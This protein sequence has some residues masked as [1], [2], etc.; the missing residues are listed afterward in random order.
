MTVL[1]LDIALERAGFRLAVRHELA[2]SGITALFGPSG[3]GKTTLLRVIAGLEERARGTVTFDGEPWQR[4]GAL[5]PA[6]RRGIGYVF[7]D[8]RLFSHLT[9]EGN[10]RFAL[11]RGTNRP[12]AARRID[13][14]AAVDALGLAPL[15]ARRPSTLSGGEQQRVAIARALLT[16]PRLLLMDE[17]LSSLDLERKREIVPHIEALPSTFGVPVIYV[18]HSIDEVTRLATDAVLLGAGTIV[19]AGPVA[20]VLGRLDVAGLMGDRDTGAVLTVR[21]DGRE[22]GV[23]TLRLDRQTL[24]VPL[25]DSPVGTQLRIRIHARD[26][27]LA[28]GRPTG[29]SIRNIL[30][31]RIVQIDASDP[32]D[33]Q[34]LLEVDGQWL[35]SRVTHGAVAELGLAPQREVF[36]L[37]KAVALESTLLF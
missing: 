4:D 19:A 36:A 28:I 22:R 34:V 18:T 1:A 31:A 30:Q 24:Q 13:F 5:V 25:R 2:L 15:L 35:R 26:V 9:V 10:L 32:I 3:S 8:G 21:V 17:P 7:Q 29:L 11:A 23:A 6:H 37:I 33:A 14:S 20:D 12:G 27:A 16:S